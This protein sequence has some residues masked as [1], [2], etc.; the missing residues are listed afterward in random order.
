M[1]IRG[2]LLTRAVSAAIPLA[3]LG[4]L[5]LYGVRTTSGEQ[6]NEY[7]WSNRRNWRR[8]PSSVGRQNLGKTTKE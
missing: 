1:G 7:Q 4:L 2:R 6:L 3:L 5:D 8:S